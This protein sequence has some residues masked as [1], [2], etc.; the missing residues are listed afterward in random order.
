MKRFANRLFQ[1]T[2]DPIF[3]PE[4]RILILHPFVITHGYATGIRQDIGNQQRAIVFQHAIG[5]W[6]RRAVRQFSDNRCLN[7]A[8]VRRSDAVFQSRWTKDVAIDLKHIIGSNLFRTGQPAQHTSAF[9]VLKRCRHVQTA[10]RI[11]S[12]L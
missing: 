1:R 4:E 3:A 8:H 11:D 6:S 2:V 9:L 5:H 10:F 7:S 12:T